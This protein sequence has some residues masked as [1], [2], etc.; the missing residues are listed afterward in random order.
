M[1]NINTKSDFSDS[2]ETQK[3]RKSYHVPQLLSLGPIQSVVKALNSGHGG[4]RTPG[5]TPMNT[6]TSA[7]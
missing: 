3:S 4:D 2:R 1:E 6:S 5:L 7:S